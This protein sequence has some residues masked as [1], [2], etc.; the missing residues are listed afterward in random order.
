MNSAV[1]QPNS[2]YA[3]K[4]KDVTE[5]VDSIPKSAGKSWTCSQRFKQESE[6]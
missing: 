5:A 2:D 4:I 6:V 1:N 3:D